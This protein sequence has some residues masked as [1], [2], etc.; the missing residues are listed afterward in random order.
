[1]ASEQQQSIFLPKMHK[2]PPFSFE[3]PGVEKV[4]GETI[5]R[6]NIRC[7][8]KDG[9]ITQPD[10][11]VKTVYDIVNYSANKFGNARC[12]GSRTV[13]NVHKEKK[14]IK[15]MIDGKETEVEKEWSYFE[16]SPYKFLSFIELQKLVG[17]LGAGLRHLGLTKGDKIHLYGATSMNWFSMAHGIFTQSLTVVTAYDTLG[18]EGLRSSLKQT[19][20]KAVFLDSGLLP[21][22]NK[23][24]GDAPTVEYIVLNNE[25][26][27]KKEELDKVKNEFPQIRVIS[28]DDLHKLGEE[29]PAEHVVPEPEDLACI[30]YTSGTSGAPKGVTI[31]HKAVIAAVTGAS[32]IVGEYIGPAD[33][34]LTYLPQ[35]HII[36]FIF[37]NASLFW[38]AS[39]GYGSPKTLTDTSVR[40]CKGDI[41]EFRPSILI[42]VPAVWETIR[43]GIV[44]KV[45]AG[46]VIARNL[47]W[48]ALA[49]KQFLLSTGIPGVN[50][51]DAIVFNKVR[52]ATGGRLR[53]SMSGGG[54]LAKDTQKFISMA[55]C[56]LISGYGLTETGG[57]GALNDPLA[58]TFEAHGD[59]PASVEEKLVDFPEAGY[60]TSN[61]PPQGELWIRGPS[62]T[63]G[64]FENEEETKLA[65]REDGWFMTGDIAEFDKNGHVKIIDR[66]KNLVKTLNGE[67]IALEKL[68]SIYRASPLV[69]NI[70]VYAAQDQQKP[71]AIIVP[72]EPALL[73]LAKENGIEGHDLEDF[74]DNPKVNGLVLREL[75]KAG[76]QGQLAAFEIIDGVVLD[77]DE[78]TP[79]NGYV[80]AAQKIQRK[81]IF[82]KNQK[83]VDKAY[84]KK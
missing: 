70:C 52:A 74:V 54:P 68:E 24:L 45:N 23:A 58:L 46:G 35:A 50:L 33:G 29:N 55:I 65:I 2:S 19:K 36:E 42:G 39:M 11:S 84:G 27:P 77:K 10:P 32:S 61:N 71:I 14:M 7:K 51:L 73:K 38:G 57:M 75:Q 9:L 67:Y 63:A 17:T 41:L 81:K 43:K 83:G 76:R 3:V 78:W 21:V 37:E 26:T 62:V 56:P 6:R 59:I 60:F 40:N 79:Q 48:G 49:A 8:D 64:Y 18:L 69:A 30:M 66:K 1:M 44:S 82:E 53:I 25:S 12:I 15:K 20:S 22:L 31:K 16:L 47:F 80:T 4:D 5:P 13:L 72:S 34:L 28:F